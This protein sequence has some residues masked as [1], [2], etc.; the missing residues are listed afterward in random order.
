MN[1]EGQLSDHIHL[2]M[3]DLRNNKLV[4]E[5]LDISAH[6]GPTLVGGKVANAVN[7]NGVG[8]YLDLGSHRDN[9]LGDLILCQEDGI[10]GSM[11]VRFNSFPDHGYLFSNGGGLQVD[12]VCFDISL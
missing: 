6:G 8:Q 12:C 2:T 1:Y 3:D 4:H 11:W 10:T 9:C 5:F 7:F